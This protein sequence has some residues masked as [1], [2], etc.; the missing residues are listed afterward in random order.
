VNLQHNRSYGKSNKKSSMV[1]EMKKL[2]V[3][4]FYALRNSLQTKEKQM[5]STP[6]IIFSS[7]P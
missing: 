3:F 4:F 7:K 6:K 1:I 2:W 5:A